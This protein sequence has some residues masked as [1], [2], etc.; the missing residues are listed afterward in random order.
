MRVSSP[1]RLVATSKAPSQPAESAI[2]EQ[3]GP[4][5]TD[6]PRQ[7]VAQTMRR[8][9]AQQFADRGP[10][11]RLRRDPET[12]G[13]DWPNGAA[14]WWPGRCRRSASRKAGS[15]PE[16]PRLPWKCCWNGR[17]AGMAGAPRARASSLPR[18]AYSKKAPRKLL[19]GT[20]PIGLSPCPRLFPELS[21]RDEVERERWWRWFDA[22]AQL[23]MRLFRIALVVTIGA[24]L[25]AV[26]ASSERQKTVRGKGRRRS[27]PLRLWLAKIWSVACCRH[28]HR[29]M[30]L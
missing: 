6:E 16:R 29:P 22:R 27:F 10:D 25:A 3:G 23:R 18:A 4:R 7:G 8:I 12:A 28:G 30:N 17:A 15:R 26:A 11:R 24:G 20:R 5:R 14:P 9:R 1:D 19:R 13:R 21:S 2:E